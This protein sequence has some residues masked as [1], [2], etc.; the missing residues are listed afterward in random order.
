MPTPIPSLKSL[1]NILFD[2]QE[3]IKFLFENNI[4]YNLRSCS[5]CDSSLYYEHKR[6]LYRCN[7]R[8]QRCKSVSIYK[9]S[10]FSNSHLK[11]SDVMLIGYLWLC[12][13]SYTAIQS[14]TGHSSNTITGYMNFFRELVISTLED[15]NQMIGGEGVIVEIDESKFG[16]NKYHRGRPINGVWVVGGIERTS[17]KRCFVV[18][19]QD[20]TAATLQDIILRH[21]APGSIVHTDLWRGYTGI[22][23]LNNITH[24][25]VN[26]S[27]HFVDPDTNVHTNTIEGLWNG[28]KIRIPPRNRTND[29]ITNHLL[30]FIWRKKN[31]DDPWAGF[32]Y[33]LKTTGYFDNNGYNN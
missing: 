18:V 1:R 3:C 11:C 8:R 21:V 23:D 17:E 16:R 22:S 19:V 15:D 29:E 32:L 31:H 10:F 33:A 5:N 14:M 20:R 26:H 2:E 27:Q 25:T 9:D 7:N 4:L 12:K 6:K 30:E 28:I 24:R 13:S